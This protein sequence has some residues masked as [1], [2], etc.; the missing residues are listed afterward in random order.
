MNSARYYVF[1]VLHIVLLVAWYTSPFYLDWRFVV[2]TVVLYHV[3]LYYAKGCLMTQGQFGKQND[4]FYYYYLTKFGFHPDKQRLSFILDY[5]IPGAL[6]L[7]ALFIQL[8]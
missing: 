4:G 8:R 3:Q 2:L 5:V 1:L 6:I 7:L